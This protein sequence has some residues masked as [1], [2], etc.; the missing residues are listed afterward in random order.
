MDFQ[1]LE[2]VSD[3]LTVP[4]KLVQVP[5]DLSSAKKACHQDIYR[6]QL[7]MINIILNKLGTGQE[8]LRVN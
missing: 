5:E 2:T 8:W 6:R 3:S 1:V 4:D 7:I